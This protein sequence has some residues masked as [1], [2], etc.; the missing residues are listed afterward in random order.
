MVTGYERIGMILLLAIVITVALAG[1]SGPPKIAGKDPMNKVFIVEN[2][3]GVLQA[4]AS[5]GK[6]VDA[7]VHIDIA[8]DIAVFPPELQQSMKNAGDH[9]NRGD[10][11][12]L[13]KVASYI[14]SRGIV[15]L[16][17][18]AKLFKRM[19][20]VIP[21]QVS[22]GELQLDNYKNFLKARR[23]FSDV[24]IE[25]LVSTD[26]HI[27]G[28]LA[29][30]PITITTLEDLDAGDD[31]VILDIDVAYFLGKKQLDP[32]YQTGTRA[33]L[34][35]V[36]DLRAKNLK[37]RIATINLATVTG[38]N[39][40]DIRYFGE[41]IAEALREPDKLEP[42]VPEK[43]TMMMEAED[44]LIAGNYG[45]AEYLYE[46]LGGKYT[47]DAGIAFMLAVTRGFMGNGPGSRDALLHAYRK[48]GAYLRAF[49]QLAKILAVQNKI[50]AAIDLV[51]T[52]QI[53]KIMSE[54][55]INYQKGTLYLSAQRP[56]D[57]L[58]Y[59]KKV[60]QL[61]SDDFPLQTMIYQA[62]RQA[63]DIPQQTLTLEKLRKMDEARVRRDMPWIYK[64]LGRLYE[65]AAL[66]KNALEV[67][68]RY[69]VIELDDPDMD[70]IRGKV[71]A[72]RELYGVSGSE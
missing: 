12:V 15:N 9:L 4:W 38:D 1:C 56:Y 23:G 14:E 53:E 20:W 52:P 34:H 27:T 7:L 63:E 49:F 24:E 33:T 71:E 60:A 58:T 59:L 42:P 47:E 54:V 48:D 68:E 22:V 46:L 41:I 55:E 18:G 67:Y 5:E 65:E 70:V 17:Y 11:D 8:D 44:S 45:R 66:Y 21:A 43:W 31:E 26:N 32:T 25:N 6:K 37:A 16:G 51:E 40:M 61:R 39:P 57:A 13:E 36:R 10:V 28:T 30:I 72:W 50:D 29:N 35:F 62:Y 2:N 69:I 19:I 64:E 3:V